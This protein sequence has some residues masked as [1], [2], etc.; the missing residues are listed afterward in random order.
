M[1]FWEMVK[2]W[3]TDGQTDGEKEGEAER[4]PEQSRTILHLVILIKRHSLHY[5][6]YTV[7]QY[8]LRFFIKIK[9]APAITEA[10]VIKP[11]ANLH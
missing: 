9:K 5:E 10:V 6:R 2:S 3:E 1:K 11:Q 8:T 4:E 7:L